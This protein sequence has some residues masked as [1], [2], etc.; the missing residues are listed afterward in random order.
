MVAQDEA[1]LIAE[2]EKLR[3]KLFDLEALATAI[4]HRLLEIEGMLPEGYTHPG[5]RRTNHKQTRSER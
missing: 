5:D 1:K 4:D 2:Y 3:E